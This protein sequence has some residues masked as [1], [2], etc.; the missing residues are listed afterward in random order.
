MHKHATPTQDNKQGRDSAAASKKKKE[1]GGQIEQ[2]SLSLLPHKNLSFV[3]NFRSL[4]SFF[5]ALLAPVL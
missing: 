4:L 2:D 1:K 5:S 3:L